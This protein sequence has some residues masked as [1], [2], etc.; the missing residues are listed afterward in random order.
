MGKKT[1]IF[2][3]LTIL[4]P[5]FTVISC[6][7]NRSNFSNKNSYKNNS[8]FYV[9]GDSL[10]DTGNFINILNHD[11]HISWLHKFAFPE[12]FYKNHW[13]NAPTAAE[14]V[15]NDFGQKLI[16]AWYAHGNN[17]AVSSA[18][19][20]HLTYLSSYTSAYGF[21]YNK[22][23]N[24][25]SIINQAHQLVKDHKINSND[26]FFIEIGANDVID[27]AAYYTNTLQE[28]IYISISIANEV[29]AIKYLIENGARNIVIGNLPDIS[30]TPEFNT[31]KNL[32]P[33]AHKLILQYN[34]KLKSALFYLK[35]AYSQPKLLEFNLFDALNKALKVA[36]SRG[37]NITSH[38]VNSNLMDE[39]ENIILGKKI[40]FS[41]GVDYQN[42][43]NYFFFDFLHPTKWAHHYI[44]TELYN[45]I[46]NKF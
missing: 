20:G 42:I 46:K 43:N 16:P 6:N 28:N 1:Q 7:N 25:Y 26:K 40:E 45:F 34:N 35:S 9:L 29:S 33:L 19:A 22:F 15:T 36:S 18:M 5:A 31:D 12:P 41:P 30:L 27:I 8:N 13:S 23:M 32:G 10:S 44:G 14:V 11:S 3:A 39:F 17:Y 38:A 21:Y 24:H 37:M 2:S 4:L